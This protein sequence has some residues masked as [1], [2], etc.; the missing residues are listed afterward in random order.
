MN[1]APCRTRFHGKVAPLQHHQH[2][3]QP[4]N[5]RADRLNKYPSQLDLTNTGS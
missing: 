4:R 1:V 3:P 2:Y 5:Y